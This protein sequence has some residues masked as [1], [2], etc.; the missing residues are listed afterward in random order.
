MFG[1]EKLHQLSFGWLLQT[2]DPEVDCSA[3]V[4]SKKDVASCICLCNTQWR[5][6]MRRGCHCDGEGVHSAAER[7]GNETGL[8]LR[9]A[10]KSRGCMLDA[11]GGEGVD[12]EPAGGLRD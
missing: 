12:K 7:D 3:G 6:G 10:C 4:R 5:E 9:G 2:D 11:T 8:G 1:I